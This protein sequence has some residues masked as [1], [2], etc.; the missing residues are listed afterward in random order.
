MMFTWSGF[1]KMPIIRQ[2][3]AAEC[4]LACVGMVACHYGHKIDLSSLRRE[5]EISLKGATLNDLVSISSELE[6]G[7]RGVKCELDSLS[8]LR[9]PAI[10]HWN[11]NHFVVLK[12]I[13]GRNRV[14]IFDPARGREILTLAEI[15]NK[16][17]GIALELVPTANFSPRNEQQTVKLSSLV[18]FDRS[19]LK[20]VLQA[21]L[22]SG[23]LQ[24][25]VLL[26]PFF[27]QLVIDEAIL[28]GD[29]SLLTAIAIGFGS[30]K[31]FEILTVIFRRIIFQLL[32]KVLTFDLKAS[33]FHHLTRLP[34]TY[35]HGRGTGDIQQRFSSLQNISYFVVDGLL[36]AIIDGVLALLIGVVLFA[37]NFM[38]GLVV[39]AFVV[40]YLIVRV[41]F[42]QLSKRLETD[43]QVAM[44]E[45]ANHFLETLTAIQT[46]KS[47]GIETERE[48]VWR[49]AAAQTVNADIR[50]GNLRIGYESISEGIIGLSLVVVVYLAAGAA[51]D[52]A[53]TIGAITAFVA[54]KGQFEQRLLTL[55]D[56]W[57]GFRLLDVHLNRIADVALTDRESDLSTPGISRQFKG[58]VKLQDVYFRYA[59]LEADV[60]KAVNLN[61]E[62]GEFVAL[63]GPSGHGKSTLLK[64]LV[65]IYRPT[66]GEIVYDGL[67]VRNWG[68][69]TIRRQLGVVMQDDTLLSGSIEENISLFDPTPDRD[70]IYW[71]AE[72]ANILHD[73]EH[74]PMGMS[75][76]VSAHGATLSGGQAQR[77]M[78]ARALYRQP[79]LLVLDEGTSQ[80]DIASET[81]INDA[82]QA[83]NITRIAAAHRPDTLKKAD[84]VINVLHGLVFEGDQLPTAGAGVIKI[85]KVPEEEI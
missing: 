10:L 38:L 12:S 79:K 25:F 1:S 54:Y 85:I 56:K 46:I 76:L 48:V 33:L 52:G 40:F 69:K 77:L 31:L 23:L 74:M 35:F 27:M 4:G 45:E 6:L 62:P 59:P 67:N 53:M 68:I 9:L 2:A 32:G 29:L 15:D 34:V 63:S 36:E 42:L 61:V 50:V 51:I 72:T 21:L 13:V 24:V 7:A 8:E 41:I 22:L 18:H 65:G 81:K 5:F 84:R 16:F 19:I 66:S 58:G 39:T 14:E 64:L 43:Q 3:T 26:A 82:L 71:A 44:A 49:N 37:Y 80:L 78:I 28:K 57:V 75:T 17:T 83:L 60:L 20:P 30:L 55:F 11:L 73:I 70:R 47:A